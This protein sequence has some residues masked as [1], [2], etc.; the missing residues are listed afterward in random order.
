[1]I[2]GQ[3]HAGISVSNLERSIAFYR[4][5]LGFKHIK[6]EPV[7]NSRGRRL[8]VPDAVIQIAIME[9]GDGQ[10]VELIQYIEPPAPNKYGEAVNSLGQVH[11][12]LKV[13]DIEAQMQ[14]MIKNG[15]E[16]IGGNDYETIPEGPLFG[17]KWVYFKDPDGTNLEL[18]E[19]TLK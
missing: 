14:H 16:F 1:M 2:L 13:D 9:Y 11:I 4:D 6:T 19:G 3:V 18:I 12:A 17:W 8:G 7:R 10:S 5:I 15:V